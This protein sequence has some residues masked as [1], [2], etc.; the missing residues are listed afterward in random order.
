MNSCHVGRIIMLLSNQTTSSQSSYCW[1]PLVVFVG[2]TCNVLKVS[3]YT[4][5]LSFGVIFSILLRYIC[6]HIH[7]VY[8]L[9]ILSGIVEVYFRW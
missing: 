2:K 7:V 5:S 4:N 6:K 8:S 9:L 1:R 3:N